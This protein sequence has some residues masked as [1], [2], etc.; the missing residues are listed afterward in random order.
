LPFSSSSAP[1]ILADDFAGWA[2]AADIPAVT[3]SIMVNI[4]MVMDL[5]VC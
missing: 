4:F 3:S 5:M 1:V 2:Y